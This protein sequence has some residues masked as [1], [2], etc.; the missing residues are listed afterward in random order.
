MQLISSDA[1]FHI[2]LNFKVLFKESMIRVPLLWKHNY[3]N[4]IVRDLGL[5]RFFS[6]V[7]TFMF[8]LSLTAGCTDILNIIDKSQIATSYLYC[9]YL[10]LHVCVWYLIFSSYHSYLLLSLYHSAVDKVH[11]MPF[12]WVKAS[13]GN[14]ALQGLLFGPEKGEW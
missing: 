6:L 4:A 5:I 9:I 12:P 14:P 13:E 11:Y 10:F 2:K 7:D 3:V 1:C 8:F